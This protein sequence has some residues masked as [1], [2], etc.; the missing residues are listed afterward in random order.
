MKSTVMLIDI[1]KIK[2]NI[3]K[4]QIAYHSYDYFF[5]NVKDNFFGMGYKLINNISELGINYLYASTL[6]DALEIRKINHKIPILISFEV[7]KDSIYDAI[8]NDIAITISNLDNLKELSNVNSKD[9][10]NVHILVDNGENK[11]GL[12]NLSEVKKAIKIINESNYLML[13]GIY[14]EFFSYGILDDN[15]YLVKENFTNILDGI[16]TK[17]LIIHANEPL[18]YHKKDK[19]INGINLSLSV[20]GI[21]EFIKNTLSNNIKA[22]TISKKYD[23]LILPDLNLG[24]SFEVVSKVMDFS[25]ASKGD[26]IGKNYKAPKDLK[27][28]IVPLGYKDGFTKAIKN[29]Y[30][31]AKTYPI[32]YDTIDYMIIAVDDT[33]KLNDVVYFI[34]NNSDV[35][36]LISI[37]HTN[38]FYLM[39]ILNKNIVKEYINENKK[40]D[41]L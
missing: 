23:N 40:E 19:N 1:N 10:V 2:N 31:E 3:K 29:I 39:S 37:L 7:T 33:V 27:L 6:E 13:E 30:I 36:N 28:A 38:R 20:L 8:N 34:S 5:I 17:D 16:N 18:M 32:I 25:F 14:T 11:R 15:F 41:L 21:E 12:K 4:L 9:K 22:K 35:H 26:V 24:L